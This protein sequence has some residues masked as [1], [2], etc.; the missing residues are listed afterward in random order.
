LAIKRYNGKPGP[1]VS[2]CAQKTIITATN[3]VIT[4]TNVKPVRIGGIFD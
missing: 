4:K 2:G 1:E 3:Q